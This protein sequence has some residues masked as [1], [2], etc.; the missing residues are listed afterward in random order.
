LQLARLVVRI[1]RNFGERGSPAVF[2]DVAKAFDTVWMHGLLYK[3]RPLNFPPYIVHKI[4]SYLRDR[5]WKRPSRWPPHL[6]EACGQ[7]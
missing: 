2:L 4:S 5:S 6:F 7:G 1:T 3:L